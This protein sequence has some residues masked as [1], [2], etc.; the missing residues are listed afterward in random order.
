VDRGIA[1]IGDGGVHSG[2]SLHCRHAGQLTAAAAVSAG[3]TVGWECGNVPDRF[4]VARESFSA[5]V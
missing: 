1:G 4:V 3:Q 5:V 2:S